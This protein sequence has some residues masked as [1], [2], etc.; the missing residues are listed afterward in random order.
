MAEILQSPL[1]GSAKHVLS[2][3]CSAVAQQR[4]LQSLQHLSPQPH[5]VPATHKVPRVKRVRRI[6]SPAVAALLDDIAMYNCC[7]RAVGGL[8]ELPQVQQIES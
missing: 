8:R 7:M 1:Q 4:L 3:R 6:K 2:Q 5:T